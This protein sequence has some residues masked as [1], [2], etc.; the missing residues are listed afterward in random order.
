MRNQLVYD[1]PTRVFH[2]FFVWFFLTAILFGKILDHDDPNFPYHMLAGLTVSALVIF[3][4]IWGF[5]G[6]KHARFSSFSLHPKDLVAYMKGAFSGERKFWAGH[7]PASSWS[8]ILLLLI[9]LSLGS[10]GFLMVSGVGGD[11]LEEVHE[12]LANSF[13]VVAGMHVL[14]VIYHTVRLK[15][16]IGLSMFDGK[17]AHINAN[18]VIA[19]KHPVVGIIFAVM[20]IIYLGFLSR[21]FDPK[22]GQLSLF[23]KV[24]QLSEAEDGH[25]EH[26]HD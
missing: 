23:G 1:Y 4:I 18:D 10:S 24:Y 3:R 12:I 11:F 8:A 19:A 20:V 9:G 26:S 2:W 7:N 6:S 25:E 15:D 5:W 16:S 17:K 21:S 13:I 22:T 14:G